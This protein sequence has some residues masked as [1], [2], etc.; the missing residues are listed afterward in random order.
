MRII[1]KI[2]EEEANKIAEIRKTIKNKMTDKKLYAVELRGRGKS[3]PEIAEK[4]DSERI[5]ARDLLGRGAVDEA[6]AVEENAAARL[7]EVFAA[8]SGVP[9]YFNSYA[10]RVI[11][12]RLFAQPDERTVLIP[13]NLFYTHLEL[14]DLLNHVGRH[15][16]AA[17]HL[18][19]LVSYAPAYPLTHIRLAI[20]LAHSGDWESV[21]AACANALQVALDGEDAGFA[22][23]R[24]AYA[25]WMRDDFPL[26]TTFAP[27]YIF[28]KKGTKTKSIA[29]FITSSVHCAKKRRAAASSFDS[30]LMMEQFW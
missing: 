28:S 3:N 30:A 11:Y 23:Y 17:D 15:E 20:H 1:Y 26:A 18:N 25:A 8:A 29:S 13:D 16:E 6:V 9:R 27:D 5:R 2:S 21:H 10:E 4:L 24:M 7:D 19:E 12:N 22:Y 14:A